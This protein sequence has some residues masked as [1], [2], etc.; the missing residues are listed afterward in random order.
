L[1]LDLENII[2]DE[3]NLLTFSEAIDGEIYA[4]CFIMAHEINSVIISK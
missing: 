4:I 1:D 3:S 2:N